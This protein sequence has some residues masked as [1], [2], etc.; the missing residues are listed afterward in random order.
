MGVMEAKARDALDLR[1]L[2][3][4]RACG[5]MT[6]LAPN[7]H[8]PARRKMEYHL[9]S[10]F[11]GAGT[12][13][14]SAVVDAYNALRR[15]FL[16]REL[17][18]I[19]EALIGP[20]ALK[21]VIA[22]GQPPEALAEAFTGQAAVPPACM[23]VSSYVSEI[24]MGYLSLRDRQALP[25]EMT[26]PPVDLLAM[27]KDTK[28]DYTTLWEYVEAEH[29]KGFLSGEPAWSDEYCE[30]GLTWRARLEKILTFLNDE[31]FSE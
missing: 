1:V 26:L 10:R 29:E 17:K 5:Q 2:L 31:A 14:P 24:V 12:S 15:G 6:P 8:V 7:L 18:A 16:L 25:H 4:K 9:H 23:I 20:E 28:P 30:D 3:A 19:R 22:T 21:V 27:L 13:Q 11:S